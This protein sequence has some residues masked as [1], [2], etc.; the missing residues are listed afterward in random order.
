M[1]ALGFGSPAHAAPLSG[2]RVVLGRHAEER[3]LDTDLATR[4]L[5]YLRGG[6]RHGA[7]VTRHADDERAVCEEGKG[8]NSEQVGKEVAGRV[9]GL[10]VV[11]QKDV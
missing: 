5:L 6:L 8:I 3:V 2:L 7:R 1:C 11:V 10:V 4:F 9:E